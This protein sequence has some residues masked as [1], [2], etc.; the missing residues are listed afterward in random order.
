MPS[1]ASASPSLASAVQDLVT[2][3]SVMKICRSIYHVGLFFT[4]YLE[5]FMT[6]NEESRDYTFSDGDLT[7]RAGTFVV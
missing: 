4:N 3:Y 6:T 2:I 1:L 7:Q 5:V